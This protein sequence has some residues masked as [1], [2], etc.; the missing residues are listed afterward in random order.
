MI[1][2]PIPAFYTSQ[3]ATLSLAMIGWVFSL[4]AMVV[5]IV[6]ACLPNKIL[7][8]V[9]IVLCFI[10]GLYLCILPFLYYSV[11]ILRTVGATRIYRLFM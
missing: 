2:I 11:D 9:C 8:Y 4:A 6:Y 10:S 3:V 5:L 1:F 7:A